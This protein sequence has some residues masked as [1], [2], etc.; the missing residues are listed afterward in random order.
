MRHDHLHD[1]IE[2]RRADQNLLFVL[3]KEF[4]MPVHS[5]ERQQQPR[6]AQRRQNDQRDAVSVIERPMRQRHIQDGEQIARNHQPH[7]R[8]EQGL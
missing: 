8:K 5:A 3:Y 7:A 1:K 4:F 2:Y 6:K